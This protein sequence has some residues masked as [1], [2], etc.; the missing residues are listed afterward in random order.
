MTCYLRY[1]GNEVKQ[2]LHSVWYFLDL[3]EEFKIH[4]YQK[5]LLEV[6]CK[7][8]AL[9]NLTKF[10]VKHMCQSLFFRLM[11]IRA[12]FSKFISVLL[13]VISLTESQHILNIVNSLHI[14]C[15]AMTTQKA[16]ISGSNS[17]HLTFL[18]ESITTLDSS[19]YSTAPTI[20]KIFSPSLPT[21]IVKKRF[22]LK[23]Q[24][25]LDQSHK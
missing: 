4:S 11:V 8:S 5:Q 16:E 12:G 9:K 10:T 2:L 3:L 19:T 13:H 6:F 22:L 15:V 24:Q 18:V 25:V 14:S 1:K 23:S 7:K 21:S 20:K 17:F